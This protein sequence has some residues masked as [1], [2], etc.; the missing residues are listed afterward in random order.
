MRV[1][2][3]PERIQSVIDGLSSREWEVQDQD[4]YWFRLQIRPYRTTDNRIDGVVISFVD[5]DFLKRAVQ[6]AEGARDYARSIVETVTSALVVLDAGLRVVSAN[7]AFHDM[8]VLAAHSAEARS[9]FELGGGLFEE[10]AVHR[11]L[12]DA[13]AKNVPF[14]AL[15]LTREVP[16]LGRKVLSLT[17][18]AIIW[19]EG[20]KMVLLAID[21]VSELR[22]L[23]AER[24]LLLASEKQS[25][26]EAE[27]AN[28]AKDL[29]LTTLSH[30]LRTPLSTM[31]VAAQ[32]V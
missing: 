4:G 24:A 6:D 17:G 3:L 18:R 29:F 25:R 15:E 2:D 20:A 19:G 22:T 9:L 32:L 10:P 30:E 11:A 27:R 12:E 26:I 23:E 31:L 8:F 21:D 28:R 1:D 7:E 13:I 5:V 14:T 16:L